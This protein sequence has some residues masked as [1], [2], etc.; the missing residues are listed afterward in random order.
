MIIKLKINI[1]IL[2]AMGI[3]SFLPVRF[4]MAED[5]I[6]VFKESQ[7]L[8]KELGIKLDGKLTEPLWQKAKKYEPFYSAGEYAAGPAGAPAPVQTTGLFAYD[9]SY[10]YFGFIC[11]EPEIT[12]LRQ[13][14][15]AKDT[16][17]LD[18]YLDDSVEVEIDINRGGGYGFYR[19]A[20]NSLG[21]KGAYFYCG[22]G[23]SI[24]VEIDCFAGASIEK[25]RWIVEMA[26]PFSSL[27]RAGGLSEE[28]GIVFARNRVAGQATGGKRSESFS[29]KT[30]FHNPANFHIISLAGVE[31]EPYLLSINPQTIFPEVSHLIQRKGLLE[32]ALI[33]SIRNNSLRLRTL[34]IDGALSRQT[35]VRPPEQGIHHEISLSSNE[36]KRISS[37]ISLPESGQYD[38]LLF[39]KENGRLIANITYPLKIAYNPLILDV[40]S[41]FYRNSIYATQKNID[42]IEAR[43]KIGLSLEEIKGAEVSL[44]LQNDKEETV[45]SKKL[46]I[47]KADET[48]SLPIPSLPTGKYTLKALIQQKEVILAQ[49]VQTI[50]KLPYKKGEVWLDEDL[51]W[52]MDGKPFFIAGRYGGY[53]CS[54]NPYFTCYLRIKSG[55][56]LIGFTY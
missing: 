54:K 40:I 29:T 2:V 28:I 44:I 7:G 48:L 41:P 35:T 47:S 26:V 39:I 49:T 27:V 31:R 24:G 14:A 19:I 3:I 16:S 51:N 4:L 33:Y 34:V 52:H 13:Q 25:D 21:N 45:A 17:L 56:F 6:S 10:L 30:F 50:N 55:Q 43:V 22:Y 37:S 36:E 20:V 1:F 38:F 42:E 5:S 12:N 46:I 23:A 15:K 18:V 8:G 53:E 32:G 11:Q 9:N